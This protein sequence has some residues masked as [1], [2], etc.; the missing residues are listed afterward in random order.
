[1][2]PDYLSVY[3]D[4]GFS[5]FHIAHSVILLTAC[6]YQLLHNLSLIKLCSACVKQNTATKTA[7]DACSLFAKYTFFDLV[8]QRPSSL[9]I[10]FD[11]V[12]KPFLVWNIYFTYF[13]LVVDFTFYK[14][15]IKSNRMLLTCH[16]WVS[17]RIY[18]ISCSKQVQYLKF[19][20]TVTSW[21]YSRSNI[22]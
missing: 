8:R 20:W 21:K 17:E 2:F 4:H 6:A 14:S 15:T 19:K 12:I 22:A 13:L 5:E 10:N 18:T 9:I 1:M 16:V 7:I 11:Q 3:Y